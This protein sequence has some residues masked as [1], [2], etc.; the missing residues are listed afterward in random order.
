M[1]GVLLGGRSVLLCFAAAAAVVFAVAL[2]EA[3]RDYERALALGDAAGSR[4]EQPIQNQNS[5]DDEPEAAN[6]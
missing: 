1:R 4:T 3:G 6:L 2:L 5:A